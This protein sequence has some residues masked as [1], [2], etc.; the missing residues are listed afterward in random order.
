M[1]YD[2]RALRRIRTA[3]G[4]SRDQVAEVTGLALTT[5][6]Y[7]DR[8]ITAPKAETLAALATALEVPVAAFFRDDNSTAA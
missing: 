2:K 5:V 6:M 8:G 7:I 3:K 4:L 1:K